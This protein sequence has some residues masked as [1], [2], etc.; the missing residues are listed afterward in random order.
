MK[1]IWLVAASCS[2]LLSVS[3]AC[4]TQEN[5]EKQKEQAEASRNLGEAYLRE[6]KY[7]AALRELSKAEAMTPDDYF[8]QADLGLA[9]LYKGETD[10]AI[11]HFKK[12]LAIK[13]DYGPARNNL[14]NAYAVKKQWDK[15]IEQYKIVT[16]NL[17]YATPQ[18]PYSNLGIAYY[19]K[20]EYG[21]A[22]KYFKQALEIT[23]DFDRALYWL[24]R[25]YLATGRVPE[26]IGR[27]EFAVEKHPQN[28]S[29]LF[30]L[31]QTYQ[32]NREYRRAYESYIRVVQMDP[33]SPLA[34]KALI[35]AKRIKPLI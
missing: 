33:D 25:T 4:T 2:V 10:K 11:H 12:S 16:S 34:D 22:E 7:S 28:T 26:A 6:G 30:E 8:L 9:Y 21:L 1:K 3:I 13:K 14:G 18:F 32:L 15:A 23:P 20:K 27:L 5:L 31:A 29:L 24:A 17:L 19:H 35:E